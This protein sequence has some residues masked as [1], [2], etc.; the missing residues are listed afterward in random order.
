VFCDKCG[1]ENRDD[2][3]YCTNCGV[4]LTGTTAPSDRKDSTEPPR[5]E[6]AS[7]IE[8]FKQVVSER[9]DVICELGRG[10]MA[11]VFLAKD[12]RLD[13]MV[14]LKLLP[15]EFQHDENFRER[16]IR[17]AKIAAKLSHPNIIPI[18]DVKEEKNF[19]YYS[20]SYIEGVSLA[21]I[22]R[23]GGALNP[24]IIARLGIQICFALQNAHE[25]NVIHRD[26]K[27]ENIL[28]DKK[29]MP[30]V[31]DFGIAKALSESK[32]SQTG[33]LIGT[34]HYMSPEQIKTGNVDGRSDIYSLGCVLYE[35]ATGRTPF[36][37]LDP[38]SLM[39]H[40]VNEMP[41]PPIAVN[42]DVPQVL[43]DLI[44]KALAKNPDDRFQTTAELGRALHDAF[45]AAESPDQKPQPPDTHKKKKGPPSPEQPPG[46]GYAET[47]VQEQAGA[48]PSA[49]AGPQPVREGPVGDTLALKKA[50]AHKT[51]GRDGKK[52]SRR[53]GTW[54]GVGLFGALATLI[55]I[56]LLYPGILQKKDNV[57]RQQVQSLTKQSPS[58]PPSDAEETSVP[59]KTDRISEQKPAPSTVVRQTPATSPQAKIPEQPVTVNPIQTK[60]A[61]ILPSRSTEKQ[62]TQ[63]EKAETRPKPAEQAPE[64]VPAQE[65]EKTEV[66]VRTAPRR[67]EVPPVR[68]PEKKPETPVEK[69]PAP[70]AVADIHWITIPG[71][72]F[73]MG[74]S[75]GDIDEQF[76][77]RPTHRVTVSSFE[78]SRDE[79]TVEQ[80]AI[81]LR[82]TG[83]PEPDNWPLQ[84]ANPKRPVVFV[85]WLDAT[86]FARWAGARIP[87]EAEWEYAARGGQDEQMYPWGTA[88][89]MGWA[90]F[91]RPWE[92]GEGWIRYL[93]ETGKYSPNGYGLNDMSGNVWEWC[94]D[95]F[96]P[97]GIQLATNPTGSQ[98][99]NGRIVRGGGWNSSEKQIR[100]AFRGP[101]NPSDKRANTGFRIVK[102]GAF[103]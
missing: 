22:I 48:K 42:K 64:Q 38:T 4:K 17:E 84:L 76:M 16:F 9:Y 83:H 71:G 23:K 77:S 91:D 81:F 66:A 29:R 39:Y 95:W 78:M 103:R 47:L 3:E 54:I 14:A 102:G 43:S 90:N 15:E 40:Q 58:A 57:P 27:P 32:L 31:V 26:I 19:T 68:V 49:P 100:N 82:N 65:P 41:Q 92:K 60:P 11:I 51:Q 67:E 5:N 50:D 85:S 59:G 21:Q 89:P 35:M 87:T 33:M 74:D 101:S 8:V 45:F 73:L 93:A 70:P 63:P 69:A 18:H 56:V 86:A 62:D 61:D 24:K 55:V 1:K 2:A 6:P 88:S 80:Y 28:I 96:G 20:M 36:K 10:G 53:V 94:Y 25:N 52:S 72:T 13:R 7:F 30:I 75:Q 46:P 12:K 37:G 99:G 34:P 44:L 79:I 97:Y 98:S